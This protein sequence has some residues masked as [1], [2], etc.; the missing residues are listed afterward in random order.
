[1]KLTRLFLLIV[2]TVITVRADDLQ[3]EAACQECLNAADQMWAECVATVQG[4]DGDVACRW[5]RDSAKAECQRTIC[6]D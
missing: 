2:L 1:M 5:A 3:N 4:D 6:I